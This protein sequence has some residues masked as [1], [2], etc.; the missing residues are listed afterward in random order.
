MFQGVGC[1][2]RGSVEALSLQVNIMLMKF[3]KY[4]FVLMSP[5][6]QS[7]CLRW[8]VFQPVVQN[9]AWILCHSQVFWMFCG[10]T[11]K[12]QNVV[13]LHRGGIEERVMCNV[14][15]SKSQPPPPYMEHLHSTCG[16]R[17]SWLRAWRGRH[18]LS[19][20]RATK[21]S[22]TWQLSDLFFFFLRLVWRTQV[23]ASNIPNWQSTVL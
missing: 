5:V 20:P 13:L 15:G 9:Q 10:T 16:V 12:E 8:F 11:T 18:F 21:K 1:S 22:F 14:L 17:F 23:F 6:K 4:L 19:S 2:L 7:S 3:W